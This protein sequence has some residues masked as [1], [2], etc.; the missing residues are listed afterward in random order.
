MIVI[1][2]GLEK[3]GSTLAF[4][5]AKAV[6]ELDGHPQP[7][8]A[9]GIVNPGPPI[10][11]VGPWTDEGLDRLVEHTT[12]QKIVVRTHHAP[13]PLGTE[14]V[15][16]LV[17]SGHVKIHVVY[18]DPRDLVVAILDD[19]V[20]ARAQHLRRH[21][22]IHTVQDAVLLLGAR[23]PALRQWGAYPS[24]KLRYEDFA[25]DHTVGPQRIADDLGIVTDPDEV[26][27]MVGERPTRK[28]VAR[29]ARYETE[30]WPDEITRIEHAFPLYLEVVRGNPYVGWF[31]TRP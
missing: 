13:L 15:V 4:E 30:L 3:S 17:E 16:E 6:L 20:D 18:R 24:L 31:D 12:G 25:F 9:D 22:D 5:M 14:R 26:W 7:R 8:L 2:Y 23:L 21:S 27:R 19:A 28:N 1:S 10:N 11:E 29:R